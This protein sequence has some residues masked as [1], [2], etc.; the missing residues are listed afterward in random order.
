MEETDVQAGSLP[1]QRKIVHVDMDAFY[2][3]VEQ[4]DNPDSAAS[5]SPS[6]DPA[7]AAS[8][9]ASYEAPKFGVRSAMPSVTA[10][11][12]CQGVGDI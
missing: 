12:Q 10:K 2:T 11:R 4:R 5:Q 9:R 3:S 7:R 8:W 6:A 1:G